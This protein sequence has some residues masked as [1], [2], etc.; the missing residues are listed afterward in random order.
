ME[1]TWLGSDYMELRNWVL[2][3]SGMELYE[4]E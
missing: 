2:G 1:V 4:A 3:I